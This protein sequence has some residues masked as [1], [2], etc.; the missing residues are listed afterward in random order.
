MNK[1]KETLYFRSEDD[2]TCHTLSHF[3]SEAKFEGLSEITLIE[4]EPD[5]NNP[6]YIFCMDSGEVGER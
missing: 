6:D 3:I 2:N 1:K 5:N 4:A